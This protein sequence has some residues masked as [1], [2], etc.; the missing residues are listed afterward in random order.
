MAIAGP[1]PSSDDAK[2]TAVK[3]GIAIPSSATASERS[4]W[5]AIAGVYARLCGP[6]AERLSDLS[7][8][9]A[10]VDGALI[11]SSEGSANLTAICQTVPGE[12]EAH[13]C[14]PTV[15]SC[16][17][18]RSLALAASLPFLPFLASISLGCFVDLFLLCIFAVCFSLRKVLEEER[19]HANHHTRTR[20]AHE[21]TDS[22][23]M[24]YEVASQNSSN[25]E[26]KHN[27]VEKTS[28]PPASVELN[29][30]L[31]ALTEEHRD[32]LIKRHGTVDL[33]PLPS[34][35]PADPYNWPQWKKVVNLSCVAFHVSILSYT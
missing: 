3:D 2:D 22:K 23:A 33:D 16:F 31:P 26:K 6:V 10:R 19:V 28:L 21:I 8:M 27:D 32:Y 7:L 9:R 11:L 13:C 12:K 25:G 20:R 4:R 34:A 35:D 1:I 29:D 24:N 14:E 5:E 15:G 30:G 18:L 17:L